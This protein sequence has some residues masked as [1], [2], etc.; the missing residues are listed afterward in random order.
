MAQNLKGE[1]CGEYCYT[2]IAVLI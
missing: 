2:Q 1:K